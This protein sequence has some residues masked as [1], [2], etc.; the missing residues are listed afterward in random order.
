MVKVYVRDRSGDVIEII[1]RK[2][3][4]IENSYKKKFL[5]KGKKYVAN[6]I[7]RKYH[8]Y[9]HG[10]RKPTKKQHRENLRWVDSIL[11]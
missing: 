1:N 3:I 9:P 7:D 8:I 5:Y 6:Y 4:K 10:T 11:K 2:P